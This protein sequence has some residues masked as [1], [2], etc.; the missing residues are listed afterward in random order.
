MFLCLF[1]CVDTEQRNSGCVFANFCIYVCGERTR[2]KSI[3]I[4]LPKGFPNN[5]NDKKSW[6]YLNNTAKFANTVI[7]VYV[8]CLIFFPRPII[9]K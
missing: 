7:F 8:W 2:I 3:E 1:D 4:S 9:Q 5:H 6:A